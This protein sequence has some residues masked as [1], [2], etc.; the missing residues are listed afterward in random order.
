MH[1]SHHLLNTTAGGFSI[2]RQWATQLPTLLF[3]YD[4]LKSALIF[5]RHRVLNQCLEQHVYLA[6]EGEWSGEPVEGTPF[7]E[8]TQN[9]FFPLQVQLYLCVRVQGRNSDLWVL[10]TDVEFWDSSLYFHRGDAQ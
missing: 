7:T 3:I 8:I 4:K 9:I 1:S 5:A 2:E 10:C 6:G